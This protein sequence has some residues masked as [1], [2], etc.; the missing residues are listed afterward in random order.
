MKQSVG[1]VRAANGSAR[2]RG[3]H[4]DVFSIINNANAA[5]KHHFRGRVDC[6]CLTKDQRNAYKAD[7]NLVPQAAM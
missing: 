6:H 5:Q 1:N 3:G 4:Q 2:C 7:P